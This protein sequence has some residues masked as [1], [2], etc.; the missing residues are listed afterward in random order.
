MFE[1]IVGIIAIIV[2]VV[3]AKPI[4]KFLKFSKFAKV[5]LALIYIISPIDLIPE[6][7][8]GPVG[9]IDDGAAVIYLVRTIATDA[10]VN[11]AKPQ[12]IRFAKAALRFIVIGLIILSVVIFLLMK[13]TNNN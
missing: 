12:L 9:F 2:I 8:L 11:V 13:N 1:I 5:T 6:A 10:A 4:F 3:F 7:V